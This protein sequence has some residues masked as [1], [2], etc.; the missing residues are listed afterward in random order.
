[1]SA[2][3]LAELQPLVKAAARRI[4]QYSGGRVQADDLAQ[5]G[6]MAAHA[7]LLRA[8]TAGEDRIRFAR[9][10]AKSAMLDM[11]R[12]ETRHRA[13]EAARL[14]AATVP[15]DDLAQ[16]ADPGPGPEEIVLKRQLARLVAEAI[17][18]LP[19]RLRDALRLAYEGEGAGR[20]LAE[21]WGISPARVSQ[22][23]SEAIRALRVSLGVDSAPAGQQPATRREREDAP[24]GHAEPECT[25]AEMFAPDIVRGADARLLRDQGPHG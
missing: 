7:T 24:A 9:G 22:L 11:L 16:H 5:V 19:R 13:S 17:E 21:A 4:A 14:A 6:M 23:Q 12:A 10:S 25:L 15:L 18:E 8:G 1:M 3:I 20:A 2:A